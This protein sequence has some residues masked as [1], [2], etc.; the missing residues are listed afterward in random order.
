M[1]QTSTLI[2]KNKPFSIII[3]LVFI[4]TFTSL[5]SYNF[6][7]V[8]SIAL[9]SFFASLTGIL[10]AIVFLINRKTISFTSSTS[11]WCLLL[12]GLLYAAHPF[13]TKSGLIGIKYLFLINCIIFGVAL[14]FLSNMQLLSARICYAII[15][16]VSIIQSS[17]CFLQQGGIIASH[18]D[19]FKVTGTLNNPNI[20]AMYL[21]MAL[22]AAFALL[23]K[24]GQQFN[25]ETT[26]TRGL[27]RKQG[28]FSNKLSNLFD[29]QTLIIAIGLLTFLT[30][31]PTLY[32]LQCR[33]SWVG[34]VIASTIFFSF[35]FGLFAHFLKLRLAQR[36]IVL[37]I[38]VLVS[39]SG[40]LLIYKIKQPSSEGRIAIW[41]NSLHMLAEK[42]VCGYGSEMFEPCYNLHNAMVYGQGYASQAMADNTTIVLMAYNEVLEIAIESGIPI[43]CLLILFI[44]ALFYDYHK[45]HCRTKMN[46]AALSG[47]WCFAVMS[48]TNATIKA[49]PVVACFLVYSAFCKQAT[50]FTSPIPSKRIPLL[51]A[52]LL[53]FASTT[54]LSM[55]TC[56]AYSQIKLDKMVKI[57]RNQRQQKMQIS[58]DTRYHSKPPSISYLPE[59]NKLGWILGGSGQYHK[60]FSTYLYDIGRNEEG[61]MELKQ[62]AQCFATP[63]IYITLAKAY[64]VKGVTTSAE[65]SL[66]TAIGIVPGRFVPRHMLMRFYLDYGRNEEARNE[67]RML[68]KMKIKIP[69]NEVDRIREYA[70]QILLSE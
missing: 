38:L 9:F 65:E 27:N 50:Q 44:L 28:R 6:S 1:L 12:L 68:L 33:T 25:T 66:K 21:A 20:I 49:A 70:Q 39:T 41:T 10:T 32:I 8:V 17:I 31:L 58:N 67:A 47:I 5:K 13:F 51:P 37:L 60:Y 54:M 53:V 16:S 63:E 2:Q 7:N 46:W 11:I 42:P 14:L 15:C 48:L 3:L 56:Y 62:A 52:I 43:S 64:A 26:G 34:A 23:S 24:Q 36:F 61:L 35:R 22:P 69:S 55:N 45:S 29:A 40:F 30:V 18:S 19:A 4:G 59:F 57:L